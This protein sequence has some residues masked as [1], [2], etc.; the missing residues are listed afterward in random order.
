MTRIPE[1][2]CDIIEQ[3]IY[4]PMV[5]TILNRDRTIIEK[6]PLKLP[7]PYLDMVEDALKTVQ[8]ELANVRK[9]LRKE[10]I[11]VSELKRDDTFTVYCFIY[12]GYEERHNYFNLRLRNRVEE[13]LVYFLYKR[14]IPDETQNA[15]LQ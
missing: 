9:Y 12:K 4:L 15:L 5:I 10:N 1:Q 7:Q 14:L 13:L 8:R 11:K 3:S 6:S 2:D